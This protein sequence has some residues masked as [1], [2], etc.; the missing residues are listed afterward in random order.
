[1]ITALSR[2]SRCL[3]NQESMADKITKL[4]ETDLGLGW[5]PWFSLVLP[6]WSFGDVHARRL[7][8]VGDGMLSCQERLQ[9]FDEEFGECLLRNLGLVEHWLGFGLW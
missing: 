8:Y 3:K 9:R 4:Q 7:R 1:M 5:S 2:G 6:L